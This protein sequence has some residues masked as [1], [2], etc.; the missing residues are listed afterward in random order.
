MFQQMLT[1]ADASKAVVA[2]CA[3]AWHTQSL[4]GLRRCVALRGILATFKV[5][6]DV[7]KLIFSMYGRLETHSIDNSKSPSFYF[8]PSGTVD[9]MWVLR[10]SRANLNKAYCLAYFHLTNDHWLE[11]LSMTGHM[12]GCTRALLAPKYNAEPPHCSYCLC[13]GCWKSCCDS[14]CRAKYPP[15]KWS[16]GCPE[17]WF[18][19]QVQMA[20]DVV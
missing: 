11:D 18:E 2:A 17:M 9:E 12:S 1:D 3:P 6:I 16:Y 20:R 19:M 7:V 5:P 4:W 15:R 8:Y 10:N 13:D 14:I